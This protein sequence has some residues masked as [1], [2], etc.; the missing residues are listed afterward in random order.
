MYFVVLAQ[1]TANL[2]V[3]KNIYETFEKWCRSNLLIMNADKTV[4]VK[5]S[6]H[7][8]AQTSFKINLNLELKSQ[9]FCEFLGLEL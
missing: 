3:K 4:I 9:K 6:L 7:S 1:N 2:E 8:C 5:F